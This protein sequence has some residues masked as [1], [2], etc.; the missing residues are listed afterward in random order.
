[1]RG[2]ATGVGAGCSQVPEWSRLFD[3]VDESRPGQPQGKRGIRA[4][5]TDD[6]LFTI[7]VY[8]VICTVLYRRLAAEEVAVAGTEGV[9]ITQIAVAAT[10]MSPNNTEEVS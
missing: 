6:L 9:D 4:V 1:V 2:P 8:C 5:S 3:A 7:V 10:A